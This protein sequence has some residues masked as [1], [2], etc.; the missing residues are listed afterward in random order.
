MLHAEETR[1]FIR[2]H[3]RHF[4]AAALVDAAEAYRELIDGGGKHAAGHGRR[5]EH[6][7]AGPLA[8]GDDPPGQGPRHLLHRREPRGGPLQPRRPRPLRARPELPRADARARSTSCSSRHLNRVTDTCIPEDEAIRRIEDAILDEWTGADAGR[9][10]L[11]PA[12]VPLPDPAQRASGVQLPDRSR[13][14]LADGRVREEPADLRARLGGLDAAATSSPR[15]ACSGRIGDVHTVRG[16][17]EYMMALAGWYQAWRRRTRRSASS[18]SAAASPATSRSASCRCCV[19]TWSATTCRCGATSARSATRPRATA[20]TPAR[21]RT[22]RSPG[23]SSA[24]DTPRFVIESDATIVA[25][26]IFA[27]VLGG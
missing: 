10:A 25:P 26:L 27:Y 20:P 12:R 22:R 2:H 23:R 24:V 8:G 9:R 21:C 5:D 3:Y 16:G 15:T 17:I 11:F 7:R 6:R 14:Q 13:R 1:A 4:N 18:R 19:R